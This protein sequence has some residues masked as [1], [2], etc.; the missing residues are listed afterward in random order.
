MLRR[1]LGC[2]LC[3]LLCGT[4]AL[5]DLLDY[6]TRKAFSLGYSRLYEALDHEKPVLWRITITPAAMEGLSEEAVNAMALMMS[7]T[8]MRGTLQRFVG[9]GYINAAVY[10]GEQQ[11]AY[12]EQAIEN[13]RTGV[14]LNGEW[15]SIQT[16]MESEGA[17]MLG[18]GEFGETLLSMDYESLSR[19]DIPF[20]SDLYSQGI[21]LWCLAS[22]YGTDNHNLS[23]PSGATSHATSFEIDTDALR[24]MLSQWADGLSLS[25]LSLGMHGAG[26]SLGVSKDEV[27][28]FAEKLAQYAE[29]V[30]LAK[31]IKMNMTFGEG[32]LLRTVRTSGNLQESGGRTSI[33]LNYTADASSTRI[34]RKYSIDFQ[35]RDWDT[36]KAT[37]TWINS[38]NEKSKS[39][40]S[41]A[42]SASG[43][44]E[45]EPYRIK[46]DQKTANQYHM[47][48]FQQLTESITGTLTASVTYAGE[49]VLDISAKRTGETVSSRT[50]NSAVYIWDSYDIKLQGAEGTLFEGVVTL[51]YVVEQ[52]RGEQSPID[53]LY[54]AHRIEDIDLMAAESVRQALQEAIQQ[55]QKA[56]IQAL[57]SHAIAALLKAY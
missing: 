11:I 30:E 48:E 24:D 28:S 8:E 47:D 10:T 55:M 44:Y 37:C 7:A 41:F 56:F 52:G 18:L 54:E 26:L 43:T 12:I 29:V 46:V 9:G 25:N 57:P 1:F 53:I 38:S 42:L 3:M 20:F 32:D 22:P 21:A 39:E 4:S 34:S 2:L 51:E 33:S 50:V 36:L 16:G 5:A 31:P 40:G 45:G 15:Y 19:G 13:G 14:N 6:P 49:T 27:A 23:V 35:P 17:A